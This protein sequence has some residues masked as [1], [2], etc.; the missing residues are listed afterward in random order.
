MALARETDASL[1]GSHLMLVDGLVPRPSNNPVWCTYGP[2]P[3]CGYLIGRDGRIV[4]VQQRV[5]VAAMASTIDSLLA[6]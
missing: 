2:A 6:R 1:E 4:A 5:D 3:N